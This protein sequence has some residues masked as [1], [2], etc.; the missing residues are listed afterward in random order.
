MDNP[1]KAFNYLNQDPLRNIVP[2]KML[3]NNDQGIE[4]HFVGNGRSAGVIMILPSDHF[5]YDAQTYADADFIVIISADNP[6]V[7]KEMLP[8]IPENNDLIF[9]LFTEDAFDILGQHHDL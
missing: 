5:T 8:F 6:D 9:K 3:A 4:T 2:L 7:I 1:Q